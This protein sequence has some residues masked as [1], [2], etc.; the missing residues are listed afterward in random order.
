MKKILILGGAQQHCKIVDAAKRLGLYTIVTDYLPNSP[1]KKICD[2]A[3]NC[4]ITDIDGIVAMCKE[5]G[6]DGVITG[7]IDPCQR[8]Y[9]EICKRLNLPCFGTPEQFFSL[10]D[11]HAFKQMCRDNAVD[12]IQEF[13]DDDINKNQIDYPVFVKPVD[14]RGSRGQSVCTCREELNQ[15]IRFAK[16]ESSNSDILIE[17]YMGNQ[18]EVQIT[19]FLI[20]G[21]AYLVRTVDSYVGSETDKLEKVVKYSIS[22]SK[23]TDIYL[24]TAH[25]NVT[26][27]IEKLGIKDGPV[28]MQGFYDNGKFRFFDPGLRFPG[29]EYDLIYKELLGVD[30]VEALVDYAINGKFTTLHDLPKDGVYLNHHSAAVLFPTISAG[31]ITE[32]RGM[33]KIQSHPQIVAIAM[34]HDVGEEI[35]WTYDVNQRLCEIDIYADSYQAL[36]DNIKYVQNTL[37]V[38]NA[39][40]TSMVYGELD[41]D[42]FMNGYTEV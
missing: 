11:K 5:K 19:Y 22:P 14:S 27:M 2:K 6:V 21:K 7:Y 10:T 41:I 42:V 17:K 39:D 18:N 8:P 35:G 31:T 40:G 30:L 23:Y 37:D 28:F 25:H 29:V 24:E 36:S 38:Q 15:A 33:D 1:A 9:A 32:I 4:N 26:R 16:S 34:R 12:V 13:S 20:N 3:Y